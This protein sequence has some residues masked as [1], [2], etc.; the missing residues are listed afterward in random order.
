MRRPHSSYGHL[1]DG[2]RL[3]DQPDQ[4]VPRAGLTRYWRPKVFLDLSTGEMVG[5]VETWQEY[6]GYGGEV[7]VYR[8]GRREFVRSSSVVQLVSA[9]VREVADAHGR[10]MADDL[11][12]PKDAGPVRADVLNGRLAAVFERLSA[13]G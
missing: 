3:T 2:R 11:H 6:R 9:I 4:P 8:W 5:V 7:S 1:M 12:D 10:G 13:L